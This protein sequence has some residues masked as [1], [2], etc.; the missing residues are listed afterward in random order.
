MPLFDKILT[1]FSSDWSVSVDEMILNILKEL[2]GKIGSSQTHRHS[3]PTLHQ[4]ETHFTAERS[5]LL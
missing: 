3:C 5:E 1:G 4:S 2:K